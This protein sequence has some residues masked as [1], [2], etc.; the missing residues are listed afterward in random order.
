MRRDSAQ[1]TL[2]QKTRRKRSFFLLGRERF[3][4]PRHHSENAQKTQQ[5]T[6]RKRFNFF[7]GV[8]DLDGL[9]KKTQRGSFI[10]MAQ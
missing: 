3:L 8:V 6:S 7:R 5:K 4:P 9:E 10:F 1:K 2:A